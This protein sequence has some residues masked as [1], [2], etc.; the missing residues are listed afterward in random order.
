MPRQGEGH[1]A[2]NAV[3]ANVP[4][5]ADGTDGKSDQVAGTQKAA[6]M[7]EQEKGLAAEGVPASGGSS[8]GIQ[9][10]SEV[11]QGAPKP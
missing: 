6:P 7:P 9:Q 4:Q 2:H 1:V 5:V 11:G 3:D 8:Q 10:G